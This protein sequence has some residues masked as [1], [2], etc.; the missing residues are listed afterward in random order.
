MYKRSSYLVYL[1]VIFCSNLFAQIIITNSTFPK[2]GDSLRYYTTQKNIDVT[3]Q[4]GNQ[5]WNFATLDR[6]N[7]TTHV[8]QQAKA[9]DTL[10]QFSDASIAVKRGEVIVFYNAKA[11]TFERLGE[12]GTIDIEELGMALP[13][14]TRIRPTLI[15]RRSPMKFFDVNTHTYKRTLTFNAKILP[16]SLLGQFANL[17]DSVRIGIQ[18][19]RVDVVEAWGKCS[20]PGGTYDVLKEKRTDYQ[21]TKIEAKTAL[22]WIDVGNLLTGKGGALD[23]FQPRDTIISYVFFNDKS[24]EEI[25]EVSPSGNTMEIQFKANTMTPTLELT[26]IAELKILGNP[27]KDILTFNMDGLYSGTAQIEFITLSTGVRTKVIKEITIGHN[28]IDVNMLPSGMNMILITN[29]QD[30]LIGH[31]K[32][33]KIDK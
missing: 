19:N 3:Q 32:F 15:E 16:D 5:V 30:K 18:S 7:L 27:C 8:Y 28:T 14:F 2:V 33:V 26:N 25:M 4:G 23:G 1:L 17:V 31:G 20:I 24:K 29:E 12:K 21:E 22:G 9:L 11:T 6:S 10:N 13:S